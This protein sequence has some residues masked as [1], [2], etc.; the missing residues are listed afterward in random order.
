VMRVAIGRAPVETPYG[1]WLP[2]NKLT[3]GVPPNWGIP[4]M[5]QLP[6]VA[7]RATIAL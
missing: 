7:H 5:V 4:T 2:L 3:N 6:S 1:A